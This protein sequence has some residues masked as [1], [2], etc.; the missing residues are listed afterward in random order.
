MSSMGERGC[1]RPWTPT[2][3]HH[4]VR[5]FR[6]WAIGSPCQGTRRGL[7]LLVRGHSPGPAATCAR[8]PCLYSTSPQI[9]VCKPSSRKCTHTP[10]GRTPRLLRQSRL[11]GTRRPPRQRGLPL[12]I[13]PIPPSRL[14]SQRD[15]A[16]GASLLSDALRPTMRVGHGRRC[17]S[18]CGWGVDARADLREIRPPS[19]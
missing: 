7:P 12:S 8:R 1:T 15:D 2:A 9:Q 4:S 6:R 19:K 17:G 10:V 16:P 5:L 13:P 14:L 18:E 3:S 11:E